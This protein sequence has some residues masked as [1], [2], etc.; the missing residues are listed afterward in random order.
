MTNSKTNLKNVP[1]INKMSIPLPFCNH[2]TSMTNFIGFDFSLFCF[3]QFCH[4]VCVLSLLPLG[5]FPLFGLNSSVP[6]SWQ[7]EIEW[8]EMAFVPC[9][10]LL[11]CSWYLFLRTQEKKAAKTS[12]SPSAKLFCFLWELD[13]PSFPFSCLFSLSVTSVPVKSLLNNCTLLSHVLVK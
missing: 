8:E 6:I 4:V 13:P 3:S 1:R 2:K 10:L 7:F 5:S 11:C 12:L 9:C